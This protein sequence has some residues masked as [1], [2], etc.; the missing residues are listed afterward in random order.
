V[1]VDVHTH[2]PSHVE[3]VPEVEEQHSDVI[4]PDRPVRTTNGFDDYIRAMGP[5]DR[6]IV[7]GIASRSG[8]ESDELARLG[9]GPHEN[10]NDSAA[11]LAAR[12]PEKVIGFMSVHPDD[13]NVMDEMERCVHD[14]DL[15][16]M[17]LAPNYQT[18]E[19]LGEPAKRVYDYAQRNGLPIVFHQGTSPMPSA[20]LWYAHPLVMD[21]IAM[22]F[23]DLIAVMAHLGHPWHA[24]C[25]AVI[26]KHANV[27]ADVSAQFYRPWSMY[28]GFRLAWEWSVFEKL[29]YASDWPVTD[30]DEAIAGLRNFNRFAKEHH[31]PEVPDEALEGIVQRDSL[32]LLGLT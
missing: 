20:P 22:A 7:F 29:L 18:F 25:I 5:V 32:K 24:D 14:L 15:R 1:I 30:P 23:P 4:R 2:V 9:P 21:E 10:V 12:Y 27:Y 19:P 3:A 8:N 13:D 6:A 28:Q 11:A 17:K 31:L 26:R 16:G